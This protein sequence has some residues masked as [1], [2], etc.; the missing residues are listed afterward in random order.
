MIPWLNI[1]SP[2]WD[3]SPSTDHLILPHQLCHLM[4]ATSAKILILFP[5]FLKLVVS[6]HLKNMLVKLDHFPGYIGWKPNSVG[7]FP[8]EH[9]SPLRC[10]KKRLGPWGN[11]DSHSTKEPAEPLDGNSGMVKQ[12]LELRIG[13]VISVGLWRSEPGDHLG[14]RKIWMSIYGM[15]MMNYLS[16]VLFPDFSEPSGCNANKKNMDIQTPQAFFPSGSFR[17]KR[18]VLPWQNDLLSPSHSQVNCFSVKFRR[19]FL[20]SKLSGGV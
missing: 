2:I 20:W 16:A 9:L 4:E 3:S 13:L 10:I 17:E 8:R 19:A 1:S 12:G 11:T 14:C 15:N 5:Q 6:T 7:W 18:W